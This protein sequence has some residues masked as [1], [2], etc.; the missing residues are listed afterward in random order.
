MDEVNS[1]KTKLNALSNL[2]FSTISNVISRASLLSGY[3]STSDATATKTIAMTNDE[4]EVLRKFF[5]VLCD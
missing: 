4:E 3:S 5:A 1:Y 2:L